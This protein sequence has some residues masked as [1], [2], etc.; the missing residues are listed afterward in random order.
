[1]LGGGK[2]LG[3]KPL[4]GGGKLSRLGPARRA[5]SGDQ[6]DDEEERGSSA[7]PAAA[8]PSAATPS[9]ATTPAAVTPAAAAPV[10]ARL[11]APAAESA[12]TEDGPKA[13]DLAVPSA[14]AAPP[15]GSHSL[16]DT[17]MRPE[18][19]LG[20]IAEDEERASY[21]SHSSRSSRSS[22]SNTSADGTVRIHELPSR[23]SSLPP[24]TPS[25]NL[26][27]PARHAAVQPAATTPARP[28]TAQ[29]S[30]PAACLQTP[31]ACP[32]TARAASGE[33]PLSATRP[34]PPTAHRP[35]MAAQTPSATVATNAC[36]VS[37]PAGGGNTA[38][39]AMAPHM[40]TPAATAHAAAPITAP[41]PGA[42]FRKGTEVLVNGIAY[43]VLDLLGKG[44]TSQVFR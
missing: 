21:S 30:T 28:A 15:A 27:T 3:P 26:L 25:A 23:K 19:Q 35:T 12:L 9:A 36:A 43:S 42:A 5:T 44:G 40:S 32:P 39:V 37:T 7:A 11:G 8:T 38:T 17:I 20:A 31:V 24:T 18:L 14:Y 29:H 4:F 1:L 33:A 2:S 34:L 16:D 10:G 6:Q 41:T 13:A 22:T